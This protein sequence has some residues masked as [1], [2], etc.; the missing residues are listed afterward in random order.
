MYQIDR[1][2]KT[3]TAVT[4]PILR[5]A[6]GKIWMIDIIRRIFPQ[7]IKSYHEP[8]VG[9]AS[10]FLNIDFKGSV[11]LSDSNSE[12]ICFYRQVQ[13]NLKRLLSSI[14]KKKNSESEYYKI[15]SKTPTSNLDIATRFYYLNRTCFN[16]LY[17]VNG[18]GRFN[19]P[20]GYR[21]IS[22]VDE[23]GFQI[24]NQKLK[25]V[26]LECQDYRLSIERLRRGDFLFVDPPY[27]VAHNK[28]GFI[29]YN[30]KIFSWN[31]QENLASLINQANR[32]GV[33]FIMTN[34]SHQS[35]KKLYKG[36]AKQFEVERFSTISGRMSSRKKIN[37]LIITNCI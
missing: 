9:G 8:F 16:G 6:G 26:N 29:E 10:V 19:V 34:A 17:R 28:N 3:K 7:K 36:V 23:T 27:T 30:Q 12:L 13:T 20:Y 4:K 14:D 15:R 22:L 18:T 24:L 31:D 2:E 35:I 5:W 33:K 32:N 21:D 25:N 37:E 11:F 1:M